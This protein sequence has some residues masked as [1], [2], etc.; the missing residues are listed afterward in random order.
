MAAG[1]LVS[2][3]GA[4]VV[5]A[6]MFWGTKQVVRRSKKLLEAKRSAQIG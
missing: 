1:L 3:G 4:V 6:L 2:A 5:G